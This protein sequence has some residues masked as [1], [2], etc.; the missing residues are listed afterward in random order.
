MPSSV[1][2]VAR[3][4]MELTI[5]YDKVII[6]D[7]YVNKFRNENYLKVYAKRFSRFIARIFSFH[8]LL[9]T[10]SLDYKNLT[11][12]LIVRNCNTNIEKNLVSSYIIGEQYN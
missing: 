12:F 9:L 10:I 6:G 2:L 8:M 5:K 3:N 7:L 4:K 1:V 11:N